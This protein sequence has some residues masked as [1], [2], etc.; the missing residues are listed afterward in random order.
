MS[1]VAER[2]SQGTDDRV[3]V[4]GVTIPLE[5]LPTEVLADVA[6][7]VGAKVTLLR[8]LPGGVNAGAIRVQLAGG[9]K[10]DPV[11]D[12]VVWSAC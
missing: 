12:S 1:M 3:M 5:S 6:S 7:V 4:T 9:A 10:A 8:R 11:G 2:R